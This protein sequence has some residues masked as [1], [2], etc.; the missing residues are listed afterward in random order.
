MRAASKKGSVFPV[1]AWTRSH[2]AVLGA[3]GSGFGQR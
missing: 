2:S 1:E 3:L